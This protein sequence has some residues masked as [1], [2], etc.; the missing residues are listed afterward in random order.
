[1]PGSHIKAFNEQFYLILS[2]VPNLSKHIP[3]FNYTTDRI[4]ELTPLMEKIEEAES[5]NELKEII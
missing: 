3:D 2:Y 1:M 4:A 5:F